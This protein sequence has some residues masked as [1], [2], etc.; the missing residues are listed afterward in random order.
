MLRV[1]HRVAL[2]GLTFFGAAAV[3][4]FSVRAADV[5]AV[6]VIA[7]ENHNWTQPANQFTGGIQQVYQNPNAPFI[8]SLV[9]GTAPGISDQVAYA[10]AYHNVLATP[11]GSNP[12]IHPSE[13]NYIWAE[14]GTNFGVLNDNEPY[15]TNG[16][17]QNSSQHLTTLLTA[18]GRTW[19][20]YQEDTD[21]VRD[22]GGQLTNIPLPE[23]LWTVPLKNLSGVFASGFNTYNFSTQ[24]NYA[25]KHNPMLFFT[26]T[27]GGNDATPANALSTHYAPLQQLTVDLSTGA[28]ADYNWITPNQYNDMHTALSGGFQGLTGDAAK[29]RQ[30]DNFL[31]QIVPA[32][33]ASDAYKNHGVIVLWWDE[34]ESDGVAGDNADDFNHTLP[35]IIISRDARKNVDGLPYASP[36]NYTHSSFLRTMQDIFRVGPYLGDAANAN[37]LSDLFKPGSIPKGH[38]R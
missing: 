19:R 12:H 11:G 13:P 27:N 4:G 3:G 18:A 38:L 31:S 20:S 16:T 30:G 8:N 9:N 14:A 23:N 22:A 26:D 32:I 37:D 1:R 17:N 21:L 5:K 25:A 36:V 15:G 7:M 34:A 28:V 6:F 10:T 33:M 29:I 2:C 24:Y 35:A